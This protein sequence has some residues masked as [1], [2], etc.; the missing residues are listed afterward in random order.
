[1]FSTQKRRIWAAV[2]FFLIGP[3]SWLEW[4]TQVLNDFGFRNA[5]DNVV[6][7]VVIGCAILATLWITA[8]KDEK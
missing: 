4:N 3:F 5:D 7:A 1:M 6:K 2:A 8:L